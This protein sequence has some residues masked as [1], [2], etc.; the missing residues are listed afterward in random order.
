M[1]W[2]TIRTAWL[3]ISALVSGQ[4]AP[5]GT[6]D[7][8]PQTPA[9][10][11]AA[12]AKPR[13][14]MPHAKVSGFELAPRSGG[15]TQIGGVTRGIGTPTT[16]LAPYK[17]KAFTLT[18][19]F[20]WSN[21]NDKITEYIF[22]LL[23]SSGSDVLF[24]A[25][26]NGTT[27][28]YPEDAPALTPGGDYFWTAQ[29]S[30]GLLGEPAEAVEILIIADP[31]RSIVSAKLGSAPT[32]EDRA[33]IFIDS[34]LWYDAVGAYTEILRANPG[35]REARQ[36]RAALYQQLPQTQAAAKKDLAG[37]AQ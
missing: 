14:Q 22:R 1:R 2:T 20:E 24:E 37:T 30:R 13:M 7:S 34:L 36:K 35:D 31:E 27:Y 10:Q 5:S 25:K 3:L 18:P 11:T 23:D 8:Q 21:S 12:P 28:K 4:S 15:G 16:L 26:V 32:P 29:P 9:N 17:G 6:K 19:L 33:G